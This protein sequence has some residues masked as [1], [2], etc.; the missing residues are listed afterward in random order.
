MGGG[1]GGRWLGSWAMSAIF[2]LLV[3]DGTAGDAALLQRMNA[4]LAGEGGD[5]DRTWAAG[6]VGL[7]HRLACFTCEDRLEHQPL[8]AFGDQLALVVDGRVDN[9]IEL[10]RTLEIPPEQARRLP[11]SAFVLRAYMRWDGDCLDRLVGEFAFALWDGRREVLV[12]ASSAPTARPLYYHATPFAFAFSSRPRGLFALPFVP[13]RIDEERVAG[14]L[15]IVSTGRQRSFYRDV[16]RLA[17]GQLLVAGC[18]GQKVQEWWQP[19][20]PGEPQPGDG[21]QRLARFEELFERVIADHLRAEGRVGI[22]MSGGLDSGSV[23]AMSAPLLGA[24]GDRLAA[25]TEVPPAGFGGPVQRGRYADETPIV[26]AIAGIYPNIDVNLVDAGDSGLL[27]T[28]DRFFASAEIPFRNACNRPWIEAI[29]E[30]ASSSGVRVLLNGDQGNLTVSWDGR[31][32]LPE[33]L[34]RGQLARALREARAVARAGR[35]GSAWRVMLGQGARPF[36]PVAV[37]RAVARWREEPAAPLRICVGGLLADPPR[38]RRRASPG[39]ADRRRHGPQLQ[40]SR[41]A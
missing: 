1:Y 5:G 10:T 28:A 24:A 22:M 16:E 18:A 11:D 2:G 32:L 6:P 40:P 38:L 29:Y 15:G 4:A 3:R 31:G 41:R 12:A 21:E 27:E 26:R 17:P 35:E 25:Y 19:D 39:R 36:L 8:I 37:E 33:L 7:G 20:L 23:A 14:L 34:R 13:R 9:R 30:R